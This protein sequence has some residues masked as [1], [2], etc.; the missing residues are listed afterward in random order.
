VA[1]TPVSVATVGSSITKGN[2]FQARD[3]ACPI[4]DMRILLMAVK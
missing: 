3:E 2:G 4:S 1:G